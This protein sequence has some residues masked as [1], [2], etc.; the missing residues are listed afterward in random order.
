[1]PPAGRPL[2]GRKTST[3]VFRL[4]GSAAVHYY[5]APGLQAT[6][7]LGLEGNPAPGS[8]TPPAGAVLGLLWA[9][10]ATLELGGGL[11]LGLNG[12]ADD[13]G[14]LLGFTL[15]QHFPIQE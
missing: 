14:L 9:P 4:K 5:V 13:I 15:Q 3:E 2:C 1:M 7:Y 6:A 10:Y 11:K 12:P 8:S